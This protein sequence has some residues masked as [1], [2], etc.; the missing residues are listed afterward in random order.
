MGLSRSGLAP[1]PSGPRPT[2]ALPQTSAD[3][4]ILGF[5]PADSDRD[6]ERHRHGGGARPASA[7]L[8]RAAKEHSPAP[9]DEAIAKTVQKSVNAAKSRALREARSSPNIST[10]AALT[11]R[12][13]DHSSLGM[14]CNTGPHFGSL[15]ARFL[16]RA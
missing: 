4:G 12:S 2:V 15:A 1:A 6:I 9:L 3:R 16:I 11:G 13:L 8:F 10:A 7:P 5:Q 14:G